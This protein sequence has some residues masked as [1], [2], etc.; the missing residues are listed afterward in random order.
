MNTQTFKNDNRDAELGKA[1]NIAVPKEHMKVRT[2]PSNSSLHYID[3]DYVVHKLNELF[4]AENVST[5]VEDITVL[6]DR[7]VIREVT[8]QAKKKPG[9]NEWIPAE[10]KSISWTEVAFRATVRIEV[11]YK[12]KTFTKS[13]VGTGH[14]TGWTPPDRPATPIYEIASKAAETDA[15]KRAAKKLGPVLGLSIGDG[16]EQVFATIPEDDA[17]LVQEENPPFSETDQVVSTPIPATTA[18]AAS[19]SRTTPSPEPKAETVLAQT[20][21]P[22]EQAPKPQPEQK[23]AAQTPTVAEPAQAPATPSHKPP[24]AAASTPSA[25]ANSGNAT[26]GSSNQAGATGGESIKLNPVTP[27]A[28]AS[29]PSATS[30]MASLPKIDVTNDR[31]IPSTEWISRMRQLR[32]VLE[33]TTTQDQLLQVA[34]QFGGYVALI[35]SGEHIDQGFKDNCKKIMDDYVRNHYEKLG[36]DI[37]DQIKDRFNRAF[38][39]TASKLTTDAPF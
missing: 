32:A 12:G 19:P 1:L 30:P 11:T 28:T 8:G 27:P 2:G 17:S 25:T 16:G 33:Q 23:P 31:E 29:A 9:T 37:A 22:Q 3:G 10:T 20:Q 36:L 4:G 21:R 14:G 18:P 5:F 13:G 38:A 39:D 34:D 24:A 15:L 26:G 35:N 7:T 6:L